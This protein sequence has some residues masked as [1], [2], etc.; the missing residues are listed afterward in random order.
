MAVADCMHSVVC[1]TAAMGTG[2][3][4]W[5]NLQQP[6][7]GHILCAGD[8]SGSVGWTPLRLSGSELEQ[9]REISNL[10]VGSGMRV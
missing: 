7:P 8:S 3:V 5:G 2:S 6:Q 4:D 10:C 1:R 9:V